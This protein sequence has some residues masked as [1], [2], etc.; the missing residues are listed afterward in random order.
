[1][2]D[3]DPSRRPFRLPLGSRA[4]RGEVTEEMRFHL[5][6]R[7]EELMEQGHSREVAEREAKARFGNLPAISKEVARIGHRRARRHS[8]GATFEALGRDLRFAVR[9]LAKSPAF[10]VTA[11]LTLALGI[12]ANAAVFTAVNG[13]LLRPLD[14]P[15]LDRL[16]VIQQDVK[17]LNIS[18]AQLSAPQVNDLALH[19]DVFESVTGVAGGSFNLTGSGEP[20]RLTGARTIGGFFD[21][22]SVQPALGR[23]YRPE[24]S[25]NGNHRVAVLSHG[26]WRG[27]AGGDSSVI[28]RPIELN[29]LRYEVIGVLPENFKYRRT[30]QVFT[31]FEM[32][33]RF[34]QNRGIWSFTAVG[35][36][37]SDL[38]ESRFSAG[39]GAIVAKWQ[40]DPARAAPSEMGFSLTS[41]PFVSFWAGELR[42]LLRILMAAVV[43]VLLIACANV[44]NLQLVR[45]VAREKEIAVRAAMGAGKWPIMRQL[46]VES[47]LVAGAGGVFGLILGSVAVGA[48]AR[49]GGTS[50]PALQSLTLGGPVFLFIAAVTVLSAIAF[51]TAPAF[52]AGR[53]GLQGVLRDA[54]R[55]SSAGLSRG[56]ALLA[57]VA[58]QVALSVMLLLGAGLLIRS[59]SQLLRVDPGF[60][61]DQVLTF[62]VS[63]PG[64]T[65][66]QPA[67]RAV[68]FD[69][70]TARLADVPGVTAIGGISDLPFGE[71]RNSSP[72]TIDGKPVAP[73]AAERHA[74]MRFVQADY[75]RAIG[76]P[77]KR[78]RAFSP[79]DREG[80]PIAVIIDESLARRHFG[81]EDPVGRTINQGRPA[82]VVGVVGAVKQGDL[83]EADYPTIYYAYAQAPWYQALYV[84]LRG[85]AAPA[86]LTRHAKAAVSEL[87]PAL[88]VF[89]IRPMAAR[90]EDSLGAR[91]LAM[92]VL[93]GFAALALLLALLGVYGVLSYTTSRRAHELGIRL[94]LGAVPGDL[95]R[96]VLAG[97]L[98]VTGAGLAAGVLGFLLLARLL[99]SVLYGVSPRDPAT[100][101]VGAALLLLGAMAAIY[102]PARRAA[103]VDPIEALRGE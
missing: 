74:D 49:Q 15:S 86:E 75:F 6:E 13:V 81:D 88:P 59:L 47:A 80:A 26:F 100:I 52:R 39:L 9:G 48:L 84:T 72:F 1:M 31:P 29:G 66:A 5:E 50:L 98:A 7:I 63:L 33:E 73:G 71:G 103:R 23:F 83:S 89:D 76:I 11:V 69:Q 70:L 14:V 51:G 56:R 38:A 8:I 37:R 36:R 67:Q 90:V 28:G 92:L 54:S 65:Y 101:A 45:S 16:V 85:T 35:L 58:V 2:S 43:L 4:V 32:T 102:L 91:R 34:R 46:F 78:G 57:S 95:V 94:A 68:F 60:Q 62:R 42:P 61:P 40:A 53:M 44:A 20:Q 99:E 18:G 21:V 82:L 79:A 87:D 77:L 17:G 19:T 96:M 93:T 12:G 64:T 97:G 3:R 24:D 10:T 25:E 41:L 55:G 22:F 27:W 30:A